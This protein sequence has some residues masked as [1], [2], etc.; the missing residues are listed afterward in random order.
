MTKKVG[1]VLT[2]LV[3]DQ[4]QNKPKPVRAISQFFLLLNDS[5]RNDYAGSILGFGGLPCN[6]AC[7]IC[8]AKAFI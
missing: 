2:L 6:H 7:F 8:F 5:L 1:L 3:N 4:I